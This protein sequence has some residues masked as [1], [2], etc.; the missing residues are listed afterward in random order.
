M[1]AMVN[2]RASTNSVDLAGY[3][4]AS[5]TLIAPMYQVIAPV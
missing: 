1:V 4:I 3:I 5:P 2:A